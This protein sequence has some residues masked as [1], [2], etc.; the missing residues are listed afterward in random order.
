MSEFIQSPLF[1]KWL[2]ENYPQYEKG[3]SDEANSSHIRAILGF[4]WNNAYH[5]GFVAGCNNVL[6]RISKM[7][8][9]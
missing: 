1:K 4:C 5:K 2:R 9:E 3:Y 6:D 7:E 8:V